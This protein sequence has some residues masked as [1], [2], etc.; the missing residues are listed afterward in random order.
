MHLLDY[1]EHQPDLTMSA[2]IPLIWLVLFADYIR[3]FSFEFE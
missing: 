3:V 1:L 2:M